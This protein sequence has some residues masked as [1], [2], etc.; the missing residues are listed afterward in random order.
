[1]P[2]QP[3]TTEPQ[4]V[5]ILP[6]SAGLYS[7]LRT[8][9]FDEL[10]GAFRR[11][12]QDFQQIGRGPF[13]GELQFLQL[14]GFQVFRVNVS[15]VIQVQGSPPPD[16]FVFIP[17]VARTEARWRGRPR[18]VGD[19]QVLPPGREEDLLTSA[20]HE[21]VG[22]RVGADFVRKCAASLGGFDPEELLGERTGFTSSPASCHGLWAHLVGLLKEAEARPDFLTIPDADRVVSQELIRRIVGVMG[23]ANAADRTERRRANPEQLVRRA[24]EYVRAHILEPLSMLNLCRE[25]DVSERTLLY[26]FKE[27]RGLSPIAYFKALRLNGVRKELKSA[28]IAAVYEVAQRWGFWHTGEF[29]ADYRRLFGELPSQALCRV[30]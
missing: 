16:S 21:I 28:D 5:N 20:N 13:Q 11:W 23:Q 24:E 25:L 1:M 19:L 15:Q 29:A 3:S 12:K 17:I 18:E 6:K 27:V 2:E 26:A 14:S 8:R 10:A 30:R 7:S 9:D 4:T 22:M